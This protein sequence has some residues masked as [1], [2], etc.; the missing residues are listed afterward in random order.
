MSKKETFYTT[1]YLI[2]REGFLTL[3]ICM[4]IG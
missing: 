3:K 4:R 1:K 2:L